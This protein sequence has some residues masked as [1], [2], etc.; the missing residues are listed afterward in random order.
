MIALI[1]IDARELRFPFFHET[2][3]F[4]G[5]RVIIILSTLDQEHGDRYEDLE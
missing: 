5:Q 4:V 3:Y 2:V 1:D